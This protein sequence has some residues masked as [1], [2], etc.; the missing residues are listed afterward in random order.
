MKIESGQIQHGL[1]DVGQKEKTERASAAG[2]SRQQSGVGEDVVLSD[3]VRQI[4]ALAAEITDVGAVDR[5]RVDALR[6]RI[7][8]GEFTPSNEAI[9][10]A[11]FGEL[12]GGV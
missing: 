8:A 10:A 2:A 7:K 4:R 1:L 6:A 5:Q 11:L 9:A 12:S 3:R